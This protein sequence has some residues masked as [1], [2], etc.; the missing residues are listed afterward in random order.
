MENEKDCDYLIMRNNG[1]AAHNL[2]EYLKERIA[3]FIKKDSLD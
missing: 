1:M 2:E 3:V